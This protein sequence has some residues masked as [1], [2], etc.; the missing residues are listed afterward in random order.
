M[1]ILRDYW[2]VD[3]RKFLELLTFQ[4]C[5]SIL[6]CLRSKGS[7]KI[8]PCTFSDSFL[9]VTLSSFEFLIRL[10]ISV[11]FPVLELFFLS[12]HLKFNSTY[13]NPTPTPNVSNSQDI[14]WQ[15]TQNKFVLSSRAFHRL[16]V[17]FKLPFSNDFKFHRRTSRHK[18]EPFWFRETTRRRAKPPP[19]SDEVKSISWNGGGS[20][21]P[22]YHRESRDSICK[23]G[24]I[25][26][27]RPFSSSRHHSQNYIHVNRAGSF[28]AYLIYMR[29]NLAG[30]SAILDGF[31][32]GIDTARSLLASPTCTLSYAAFW[33]P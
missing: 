27:L 15:L 22:P 33:K 29:A 7:A 10:P 31:Q 16:S 18:T 5:H 4:K 1:W 20:S 23:H 11:F 25:T 3:T 32:L 26:V 8:S 30:D 21:R 17:V 14:M 24:K 2:Y 6:S 19:R 9:L 28:A 13:K 12:L